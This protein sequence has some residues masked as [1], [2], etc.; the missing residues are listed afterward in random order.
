MIKLFSIVATVALAG[1]SFAT[2]STT[3]V[4]PQNNQLVKNHQ[5]VNVRTAEYANYQDNS[6]LFLSKTSA[7][8]SDSI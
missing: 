1:A 6:T 2:N 4:Y 8:I 5:T 7:V 3:Y